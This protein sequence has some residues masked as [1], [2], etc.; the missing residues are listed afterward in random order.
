MPREKVAAH[1]IIRE[2]KYDTQIWDIF[3]QKRK[4]AL[5]L[6]KVLHKFNPFVHGSIARGDINPTSDIDVIIPHI[7]DEF[8]LIQPL[9]STNYEIKERWLV[10]ATPLSAIKANLVLAPEITITIP[11]IP[12]YPREIQFYDFGGKVGLKF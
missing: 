10:Q 8:K 2:I 6:M 9:E 1:Y 12:F 5:E 11:L 3:Y 4:I 7:I